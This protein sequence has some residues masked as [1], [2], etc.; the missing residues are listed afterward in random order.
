MYFS[1]FDIQSKLFPYKN[2]QPWTLLCN[3]LKS[4]LRVYTYFIWYVDVSRQSGSNDFSE[5][6]IDI[7]NELVPDHWLVEHSSK[8]PYNQLTSSCCNHNSTQP[9]LLVVITHSFQQGALYGGGHCGALR[10]ANSG[11]EAVTWKHR[12]PR[13]VL[14]AHYTYH[15]L[16]HNKGQSSQPHVQATWKKQT[17]E[18]VQGSCRA[19][20]C[21]W[22]YW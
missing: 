3:N 17:V 7:L 16:V 18:E 9:I 4:I 13:W 6:K 8:V 20:D 15:C 5:L 2:I 11:S 10:V 12:V 22:L 14:N 21:W 1:W 19:F